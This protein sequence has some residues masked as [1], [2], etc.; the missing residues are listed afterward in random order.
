MHKSC[1]GVHGSL[2]GKKDF[3]CKKCIPG[4]VFEDEVG[5]RQHRSGM[6]SF[7]EFG[8]RQHRSGGQVFLPW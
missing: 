7:D 6:I 8:W 5:W 2:T 3:T 1:S 4:V